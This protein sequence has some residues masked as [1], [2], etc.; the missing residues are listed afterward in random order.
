MPATLPAEAKARRRP[1]NTLIM[2]PCRAADVLT[3]ARDRRWLTG[4][5]IR[6]VMPGTPLLDRLLAELGESPLDAGRA[7]LRLWGQTGTMPD[8][9]VAGADPVWMQAGLEQVF[10]HIPPA[11]DIDTAA[12][13]S[14]FSDLQ[15]ALLADRDL[16]L[17]ARDDCGYLLGT[18]PLPVATL[19][20]SAIDRNQ[21]AKFTPDFN[22]PE[23][24]EYYSLCSE[25][26]MSMYAHP[27][28]QQR[29]ERGQRPLNALWLWGGGQVTGREERMLPILYAD[30]AM[31][32]GFSAYSKTEC[33]EWPGSI[34]ACVDRTPGRFI[35]VPPPLASEAL[36]ETL[37]ELRSLWRADRLPSLT[38][39]FDD[40]AIDLQK[41][42]RRFFRIGTAAQLRNLFE[43]QN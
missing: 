41:S 4:A 3:L 29:E 42:W 27:Y 24:A 19:P 14:M 10:L 32:H 26:E 35:A 43:K 31:L 30:D 15:N 9:W 39:L 33:R 28:N 36:D 23:S 18:D 40:I 2:L 37:I 13:Q 12:L 25:I 21:P 16:R 20:A 22:S 34:T 38:L 7:A 5:A 1:H 17:E 8:G 11:D 6:P